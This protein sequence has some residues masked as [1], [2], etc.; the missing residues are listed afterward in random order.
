[1]TNRSKPDV[2][3][4]AGIDV[5]AREISVAR[6]RSK[7]E[8]PKFA[9]FANSPS[10]HKALLAF[11]LEGT[12]RIRV[13]LES[14]GNYS[15]DLA[16]AL[17]AHRQVEVSVINPRRARRFA[18]SL[19]ERSKTDPVDAHVL[20]QYAIRMPWVGWQ[21]PSSLALRL[22]AI[23]RAIESLGVMLTQEKN[24]AH[25]LG[26]S[27]ALPALV[28]RERERHQRY[29]EHR[30]RQLRREARRLIARDSELERRFR[31]MLTV[32]GIGETSAL[33]ILGELVVLSDTMD[34]RQW[35]AFSG[36]DPCHF[37]SGT[38]VEKRPRISRGG[39]RHLRHALYMPALGALC[40]EPHLR[41]FYQR[42][43]SRGKK[44]LQAVVAVMRKLLHALFAMFRSN[45]SYDGSKLSP[46]ELTTKVVAA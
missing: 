34:A 8:N 22:R 23:T 10:R 46:I 44:P 4:F 28:L 36:L 40:H 20:C 2:E 24:R 9:T 25:A 19:G 26:S 33:Q 37:S 31:L 13:C 12:D 42:L 14:S 27:Q 6:L 3:A 16:L 29:L 45:S 32:P 41:A 18:E 35:V 15:L 7:E 11:L 17:H 43:L 39:S 21:P 38:S 1:M 30:M 5:S